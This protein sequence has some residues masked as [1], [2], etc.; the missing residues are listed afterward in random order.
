MKGSVPVA[1]VDDTDNGFLPS[2]QNEHRPWCYAIVSDKRGR[3][4]VG[5]YLLRERKDVHFIVL[6]QLAV[7]WIL[8]H[9]REQV[10]N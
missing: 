3:P 5:V 8:N 7:Y 10:I 4:T 2:L 1:T 6:N 9:P